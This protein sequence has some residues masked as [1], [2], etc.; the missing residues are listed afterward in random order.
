MAYSAPPT[1]AD[2]SA[3]S[4]A[5]LNVLSDDIEYLEGI[6]SRH[7]LPAIVCAQNEKDWNVEGKRWRWQIIYQHDTLVINY[8]IGSTLGSTPDIYYAAN[9]LSADIDGGGDFSG[10]AGTHTYTCDLSTLGLTL[11]TV[12]NIY[13]EIEPDGVHATAWQLNYMYEV[14]TQ[15]VA[16]PR[17]WTHGEVPT[18]AFMN[19]Y[20]NGIVDV[21]D[22]WETRKAFNL[23]SPLKASGTYL[24]FNEAGGSYSVRLT[25]D[26]L[27]VRQYRWLHYFGDGALT[28]PAGINADITLDDD[29]DVDGAVLDLESTW[30]IVGS[31][32]TV[33]G[34]NACIESDLVNT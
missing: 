24:W 19:A 10:H 6:R 30:A 29:D 2:N 12:Y 7:N 28:D 3:P 34:V 16:L 17:Q 4:A 14:G 26:F 27:F 15:S 1:F 21:Y 25:G 8:T 11:G 33:T 22:T 20:S 9:A 23:L 5:N 18:A 31:A 13:A 32:Y